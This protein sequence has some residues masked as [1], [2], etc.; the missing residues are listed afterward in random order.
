MEVIEIDLRRELEKDE[1]DEKRVA[2]YIDA[3]RALE[4]EM[5]KTHLLSWLKIRKVL[6]KDQRA[7]LEDLHKQRRK[8]WR[9][10]RHKDPFAPDAPDAP[11]PPKAGKPGKPPKAPKAVDPFAD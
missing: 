4:A 7:K 10:Q 9:E 8:E 11:A 2:G 3:L 5:R 1:P 6:T